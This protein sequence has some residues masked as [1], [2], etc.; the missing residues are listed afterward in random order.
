[1]RTGGSPAALIALRLTSHDA[2]LGGVF[3]WIAGGQRYSIDPVPW[4]ADGKPTLNQSLT[5]HRPDRQFSDPQS[6]NSLR[7]PLPLVPRVLDE[8]VEYDFVERLF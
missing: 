3:D 5:A 8:I 6:G 4:I 2:F 1:M 7:G